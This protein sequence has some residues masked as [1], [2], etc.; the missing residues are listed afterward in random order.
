MVGTDNELNSSV[1]PVMAATS[2]KEDHN[3]VSNG[4]SNG[5]TL[6]PVED[7]RASSQERPPESQYPP[8][9]IPPAKGQMCR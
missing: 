4:N 9:S 7:M 1:K 6:Q 2:P 8:V 5:N 3:P